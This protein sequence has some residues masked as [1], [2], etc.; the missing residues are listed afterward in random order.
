MILMASGKNAL[1]NKAIGIIISLL[2]NEPFVMAHSTGN[3]RDA[4]K[5]VA[6][7]AFTAKSSPKMPAA[8]R[9]ATLVVT[10][11]SSIKAAI[12][13][14]IAKKPDAIFYWGSIVLKYKFEYL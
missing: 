1:S 10:A 8:L 4:R 6:F 7:S 3:S 2:I 11:I 5:P 12:S 13:S 14:K 9:A